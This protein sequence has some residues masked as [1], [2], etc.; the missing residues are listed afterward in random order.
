MTARELRRRLE[1]LEQAAKQHLPRE[2][3]D[4][5]VIATLRDQTAEMRHIRWLSRVIGDDTRDTI[6]VG[7]L[8]LRQSAQHPQLDGHLPSG[9]VSGAM[10]LAT[11]PADVAPPAE[12]VERVA[13]WRDHLIR[14]FQPLGP[15]VP[16]PDP[17]YDHSFRMWARAHLVR[18]AIVEPDALALRQRVDMIEHDQTKPGFEPPTGARRARLRALLEP[19]D[20]DDDSP[21]VLGC[22]GRRRTRH[23]GADVSRP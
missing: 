5:E 13:L 17:I 1:R 4:D 9:P 12:L 16:N 6:I 2:Y 22:G 15:G 10:W 3:T 19:I 18:S 8:C 11:Y 7:G 20:D 23:E 14:R 21:I